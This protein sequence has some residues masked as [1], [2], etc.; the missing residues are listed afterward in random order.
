MFK[1][2]LHNQLPAACSWENNENL[3]TS[4]VFGTIA[5]LPSTVISRIL[6]TVEYLEPHSKTEFREPVTF[7]FWP[8]W[9]GES[10]YACEPEVVISTADLLVLIEAKLRSPF[11][12]APDKRDQLDREWTLGRRQAARKAFC[13]ITVTAHAAMPRDEI[14]G[15]LSSVADLDLADVGWLNWRAIARQ[16]RQVQQDPTMTPFRGWLTD[17]D[18]F[19]KR[20]GQAPFDGFADVVAAA[21]VLP[22]RQSLFKGK[23]F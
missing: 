12:T 19:L 3:L 9:H 15:Q 16:I 4:M 6:D 7:D 13:L 10:E 11:G 17:L 8:W 21:Q 2:L 22:L 20:V 18:S 14:L 23:F 5:N 1:A